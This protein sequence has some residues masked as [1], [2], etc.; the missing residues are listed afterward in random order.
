MQIFELHF[1]P[2]LKEEQVFDSFVYEPESSYEKK[3]GNLYMVGELQNSVNANKK[4]LDDIAQVFKKHYYSLSIKSPEKALS[5]ASKKANEFLSEEVK[6]ENIG[7]LGN[8]NYGIISISNSS[9]TFTKTG[10]LKILLL[11]GGQ[12]I[13]IGKDLETQEIDPYP[14]KIFFNVVSGKLIENDKLLLITSEVFEFLKEQNILSKLAKEIDAKI[15]KRILPPALFNNGPGAKISGVCFISTV[16][17]KQERS[18][19][20]LLENNTKSSFIGKLIS[21]LPRIKLPSRKK[22]DLPKIKVSI[23]K[24]S[25]FIEKFR[26]QI[27]IKKRVLPIIALLLVLFIGFYFFKGNPEKK[28]LKVLI[29]EIQRKVDEAENLLIL[30]NEDD[31]NSLFQ[32]AWEE[33]AVIK[34]TPEVLLLKDSIKQNLNKINKIEYIDNPEIAVDLKDKSEI[35]K[36]KSLALVSGTNLIFLDKLYIFKSTWL[37]KD[38]EIDFTP[39]DFSSYF[40]NLYFL[41][42][43]EIIKYS[44]LSETDWGSGKKWLN[45]KT[46][47]SGPKSLT[48]DESVFI[49]NSNNSISVYYSGTHK[50][51]IN[52]SIFPEIKDI[53]LIRTKVDVPYLYLLEPVN[54]RLIVI[55]KEGNMIK[56][57]QSDR[58]DN[59][60]NFDVSPS[61]KTMYLLNSDTIYKISL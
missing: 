20:I 28:E 47:C 10:N 42:G 18:E 13:D 5:H 32:Q 38:I 21:K 7:W 41:N 52:L 34:E 53:S 46:D 57:F 30:D 26:N 50:K 8:L 1:N 15:I 49:L 2:K 14:L 48:V 11:R 55:D 54:N 12:I 33:I 45:D 3:L 56:Q 23:K 9:L 43:C 25:P 35:E 61:G 40:S 51:T 24:S 60:T 37:E 36:A 31:A 39:N 6:K 59:L 22:K 58:F 17:T 19:P 44:H 16:T 27:D 29:G 4:L